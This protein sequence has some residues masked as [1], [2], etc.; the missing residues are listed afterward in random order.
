[1]P[2]DTIQKEQQAAAFPLRFQ[3]Q[4]ESFQLPQNGATAHATEAPPRTS[5]ASRMK[6]RA[7]T[8]TRRAGSKLKRTSKGHG[9]GQGEAKASG[10]NL[11]P[12][13]SHARWKDAM[14]TPAS[15]EG[16]AAP[17]KANVEGG[18]AAKRTTNLQT[19]DSSGSRSDPIAS[20]SDPSSDRR[21]RPSNARSFAESPRYPTH[22]AQQQSQ[23][24]LK[25]VIAPETPSDPPTSR[26]PA[27]YPTKTTKT[28]FAATPRPQSRQRTS[29][30]PA[31][32]VLSNSRHECRYGSRPSSV[33]G[34]SRRSKTNADGRQDEAEN[35]RQGVAD[36]AA[37]SDPDSH[38]QDG[39]S[40]SE[41]SD[42]SSQSSAIRVADDERRSELP[43]DAQA[44]TEVV[45]TE[46]LRRDPDRD[47][48]EPVADNDAEDNDRVVVTVHRWHLPSDETLN[49]STTLDSAPNVDSD[50]QTSPRPCPHIDDIID[51]TS[52]QH[53]EGA[54]NRIEPTIYRQLPLHPSEGA[55]GPSV[56]YQT[57]RR[58]PSRSDIEPFWRAVKRLKEQAAVT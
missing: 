16:V 18:A 2:E 49:D 36:R 47:D 48:G 4:D 1:M 3:G 44:Q 56:L 14:P 33:L 37:V 57:F 15:S 43:N 41:L 39:T 25:R 29:S 6:T 35:G 40:S 52:H 11:R 34:R 50:R 10:T 54:W 32:A 20:S 22:E 45:S 38:P 27:L 9:N 7:E 51:A 28:A 53:T 12:V 31:G 5:M 24:A 26:M 55:L 19:M 23:P 46:L 13:T 17:V 30:G 58:P 21:L 8:R 42:V